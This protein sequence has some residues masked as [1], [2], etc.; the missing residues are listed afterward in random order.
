MNRKSDNELLDEVLAE[1]VPADF[2]EALFG[3]TLRLVH[4]R[5]R[6]RQVR[7]T[8]GIVAML[9]LLGILVWP[10]K[11]AKNSVAIAP[12]VAKAAPKNYTVILTQPLAASS[13]VTTQPQST[14]QFVGPKTSIEIVQTTAGDYR[15]IDDN[16]LLALLGSH[17]AALVRVGP[18]SE[19][20]IFANPG[21][22]QGFPMN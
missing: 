6:L 21:D 20:L 9:V 18:H 13:I 7:N 1:S 17:S 16:E 3:E 11:V 8:A 12:P 22:A 14:V 2:R 5:R 4:R 19:K 15:I 10:G